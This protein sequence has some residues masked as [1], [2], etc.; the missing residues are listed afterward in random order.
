MVEKIKNNGN[1]ENGIFKMTNP[2]DED[3]EVLWNNKKYCIPAKSTVPIIIPERSLIEIQEIRKRWALKLAQ[4]IF[5]ERKEGKELLKAS[6]KNAQEGKYQA[7]WN[8]GALE[9]ILQ[10]IL[11]PQ[12]EAI[13]VE[14]EEVKSEVKDVSSKPV[15]DGNISALET[16][17]KDEPV[18]EFRLMSGGAE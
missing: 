17:F 15:R 2:S 16:E 3:F 7:S 4:K 13:L 14:L 9:P 5:F 6:W 8:E 11:Q 1:Y 10:E 12:S 18:R